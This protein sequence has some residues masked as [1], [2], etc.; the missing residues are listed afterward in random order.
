MQMHNVTPQREKGKSREHSRKLPQHQMREV[1]STMSQ[2]FS[3][4]RS[5]QNVRMDPRYQEPPQYAE[6]NYH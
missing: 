1:Q 4:Q 5:C 2:P 3:R 6:V